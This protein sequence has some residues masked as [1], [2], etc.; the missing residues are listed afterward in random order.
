MKFCLLFKVNFQKIVCLLRS[1]CKEIE[2][3]WIQFEVL[4]F[5][6]L[7]TSSD[8]WLVM[9]RQLSSKQIRLAISKYPIEF[10]QTEIN[11]SQSICARKQ[12][13]WLRELKLFYL[14]S[15]FLRLNPR[16]HFHFNMRFFC[17]LVKFYWWLFLMCPIWLPVFS[18]FF[19][20]EP[21]LLK[22]SILAWL[23]HHF[24]LALDD[25]LIASWVLYR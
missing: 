11:K 13:D 24:H 12:K 20:I 6:R 25:L 2:N 17:C 9:W 7:K 4:G 21:E 3:N 19:Y 14:T 5:L 1:T 22:E 16:Y 10:F 8:L 18:Y 23:W 15:F